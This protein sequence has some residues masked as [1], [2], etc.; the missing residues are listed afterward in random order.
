MDG[1]ANELKTPSAQEWQSGFK[2]DGCFDVEGGAFV[3]LTL[4]FDPNLSIVYN[5]GPD[6]YILKPVI[7]IVNTGEV[8]INTYNMQ[9]PYQGQ[10]YVAQF[11]TGGSFQY[12]QS[13]DPRYVFVGSYAYDNT[14]NLVRLNYTNLITID[15]DCSSCGILDIQ[16]IDNSVADPRLLEFELLDYGENFLKLKITATGETLDFFSRIAFG[17]FDEL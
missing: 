13:G 6:R 9:T 3:T 5:P 7:Q 11:N 2:I 10:A 12:L 1:V 17:A 14:T 15:P 8:I 4:D 16:P